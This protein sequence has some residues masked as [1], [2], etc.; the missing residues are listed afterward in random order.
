MQLNPPVQPARPRPVPRNG[1]SSHA[2]RA[3]KAWEEGRRLKDQGHWQAAHRKFAQAT[4]WDPA[5]ALYW[6]NLARCEQQLGQL[7]AAVGHARH[8]FDLDRRNEVA[9]QLLAHLM[10]QAQDGQ[11]MRAV[12]DELDPSVERNARWHLLHA[13][14][15]FSANDAEQLVKHATQAMA[16]AGNDNAAWREAIAMMGAGFAMLKQYSQAAWCHRMVLDRNPLA[17]GSAQ[18]AAHYASWECDWPQL[19]QDMQR[20]QQCIEA[21]EQAPDQAGMELPVPFCLLTLT[22]DPQVL[23]WNAEQAARRDSLRSLPHDPS[24]P[25]PRPGGRLRIGLVSSDLHMHATCM[26]LAEMLEHL[27]RSR[28]ELWYYASGV[29][30]GSAMRARVQ[31]TASGW[32]EIQHWTEQRVAAQIRADEIG[33]LI[34]L[35]G[36][37]FG[38]R[39]GVFTHRPAPI[40]VSW[41]GYPGTTGGSFLDYIIGDPVVTPIEAQNQFVEQIAQMPHCYQ[42]NDSTRSQPAPLSRSECGLPETGFVFASF[43]QSYKIVPEVFEAWCRILDATPGSLLWLMVPQPEIQA[44]LRQA[45]LAQGI[46]GERLVFAPFLKIEKHRARLPNVDLFLDSFPCSGH[47]TA[48]DALWAGVP[49]LTLIGQSFASRVAAS[50]LHTLGVPELVCQDIDTYL[51]QAVRYASD[52]PLL[53]ALRHRIAQG[54]SNSPLFNGAQYAQDFGALMLRMVERQEAG[55]SPASLAAAA[56]VLAGTTSPAVDSVLT[57][58]PDARHPTAPTPAPIVTPALPRALVYMTGRNCG[59]YVAAAIDSVMWQDHPQVHV[60]FVDDASTDTTF[61]TAQRQLQSHFAGRHT[62]VRNPQPL[63]KA[64]SAHTHLRQHLQVGDFVVIVDADD[65]LIIATA[66]SQLAEQYAA[67]FDVVWTN[68]ETDQGGIGTNRALDPRQAPRLQGWRTSHCFSFRSELLAQVPESYFRDDQGQWLAAACDFAIAYPVLDQT[69]RYKH[70]PIRAYRYT[71]TNPQSHHNRDTHATGLSSRQQQA[72]ARQVLAKPALPCTREALPAPAGNETARSALSTPLTLSAT[73]PSLPT[74]TPS[75][76]ASVPALDPAWSQVAAMKLAE[77]CPALLDLAMDGAGLGLGLD[78][79]QTWRWWQWLKSGTQSPRVLEIGAGPVAA[80]L[81]AMVQAQGGTMTSACSDRSRALGLYARLQV[82]G[83][84]SEVLHLPQVEIELDGELAQLPNLQLLSEQTQAYDIVILSA[85]HAGARPR[86]CRLALAMFADKLNPQG[87]R[88]CLWS[89]G[90]AELRA[91]V[92]QRWQAL[93]PHLRYADHA[94]D[95]Q[96]LC[97][98]AEP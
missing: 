40:Q 54:R 57:V 33:V 46:A 29:D 52:A 49:V 63:G 21:V 74:L 62:L 41:L 44:R 81:H 71:A 5:D 30:D 80:A 7:E 6:L 13:N 22:D 12:L 28:F 51:Q 56:P 35:K 37:T 68:F 82:A 75:L 77:R 95:G 97:V 92:A 61:E 73:M 94:L 1:T 26:L 9:C 84:E 88:I 85:A 16:L 66:L 76:R 39:L 87:F 60:L 18:Y 31:A 65:Q 3:R 42:P 98:H 14:G 90:D 2:Q 27:D 36:H 32:H 47:T 17:L 53:R 25:V 58:E 11:A 86:D 15:A 10:M 19:S 50:L 4:Q 38:A 43:N 23:R 64:Y 34:D 59:R 48:S 91:Q 20:L 45:A 78:T 72:C 55:L 93:A 67:G 79:A 83:I 24:R 8:A 89:P 70:L 96:A 69:R